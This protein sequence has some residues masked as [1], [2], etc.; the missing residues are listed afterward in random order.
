MTPLTFTSDCGPVFVANTRSENMAAAQ[1]VGLRQPTP[2]CSSCAA[3]G[4]F[5]IGNFRLAH[6]TNSQQSADQI[7]VRPH[8]EPGSCRLRLP[9][10]LEMGG[11]S[12]GRAMTL[13]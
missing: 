3:L 9:G 1:S 6:T 10:V 8:S 5:D 4:K 2:R 13:L 12:F 11:G 7:S